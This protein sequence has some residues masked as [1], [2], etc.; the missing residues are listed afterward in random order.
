MSLGFNG[1][2]NPENYARRA[3]EAEC[4][5]LASTAHGRNDQLNRSSY[6]V[7]QLVGTGLID[8]G[9]AEHRLFSAAQAN[10]Y[11]AKDGPAAAKAT[12][13]SGIENGIREPRE[14]LN[15]CPRQPEAPR[16]KPAPKLG[17]APLPDWTRPNQDGKPKFVAVGKDQP[18]RYDDEL[19]RHVYWR[20]GQP[21]RVK[22][23]KETGEPQWIDWY[24][25]RRPSD[26][27]VGWQAKKPLGYVPVP[28]IGPAGASD[29]F[30]DA[31]GLIWA[32][33]EKDVDTLRRLGLAAFTFGSASDIPDCAELLR[34]RDLI[35]T[36]DNDEAGEKGIKAKVAAVIPV[37]ACV[38]VVRFL[39]LPPGGDV[40][41]FFETAGAE[42]FLARARAPTHDDR[43]EQ[44]EEYQEGQQDTATADDPPFKLKWHGDP[45]DTPLKEWLV[46]KMLPKA[47]LALLSGQWGTYK[48]FVGFDL[49]AA[50][51]T[52]TS[53]AGAEVKRRGGVLWIAVE[54]QDEV[55]TRLAGIAQ[56][57][58]AAAV[59]NGD[60]ID[61]DHL[62][63][64][65]VETC[66]TLAADDALPKLRAIVK[67]AAVGMRD[68]YGLP[69]AV[70]LI[71]TL[72]PAAGFRD[73]NDTAENQRVTSALRAIAREFETLVIAVD[74][75]GKDV[76][77]GTR[78]SSVKEDN[79]D[80]VLALLADRDLSGNVSNPRMAVRKVRGAPTGQEIKF[81]K[82][83]VQVDHQG[84][85]TLVIDWSAGGETNSEKAAKEAK[86]AWSGKAKY[87][88]NAIERAMID[89]GSKIRPYGNNG[90]EV[91]AVTRDK[92]RA[93]FCRSYTADNPAA[94]RQAF[95]RLVDA[96]GAQ[97]L[98]ASQE[99]AGE[100]WI[101]FAKIIEDENNA[102]QGV[103]TVTGS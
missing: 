66:P 97:S 16:T 94:K 57:K 74:H 30:A 39:D 56:D 99:I 61:P 68:R 4:D 7:G 83:V 91:K 98:I 89:F 79:S 72:S 13:A 69:I 34:N 18:T 64:V 17:A 54:G 75:F 84:N 95:K 41:D 77:T 63:F 78:N 29:P 43:A 46:D 67:A 22:I 10:G 50:V 19:R 37:A 53:F 12:I 59:A 3:F 40:S 76:T 1:I 62:P 44:T 101:W 5:I 87:L 102:A 11:V 9:E 88:K 35:V 55:R 70:V 38:R 51:M 65:W 85:S 36:G 2:S 71:D 96:A 86:P 58:I 52:Q 26:G 45:D 42:D 32:E 80:A 28:Y 49:S 73:A 92:I 25:V 23:K 47:G 93:E 14:N 24:R 27:A 103:T 90:P 33:G 21:V 100:D 31:G 20:D 15:G 6:T 82:R 48:T 60:E 81:D 8:R